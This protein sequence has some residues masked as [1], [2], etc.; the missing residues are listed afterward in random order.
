MQAWEAPWKGKAKV[1]SN[2][3][4]QKCKSLQQGAR[5]RAGQNDHDV[6]NFNQPLGTSDTERD[7]NLKGDYCTRPGVGGAVSSTDVKTP[8]SSNYTT[9]MQYM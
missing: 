1:K 6:P 5:Q 3:Y 9:E 4:K 2:I 8:L 7:F